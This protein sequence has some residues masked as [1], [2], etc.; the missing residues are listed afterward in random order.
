LPLYVPLYVWNHSL[1]IV[2]E[3]FERVIVIGMSE[4]TTPVKL[5]RCCRTQ[6]LSG[7]STDANLCVTIHWAEELGG[8]GEAGDVGAKGEVGEE[9][10]PPQAVNI[11]ATAT[12]EI[13]LFMALSPRCSGGR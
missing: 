11:S 9:E 1:S 5:A 2:I 10:S 13:R 12:V 4:K 8:A 7:P 6:Q 3:P